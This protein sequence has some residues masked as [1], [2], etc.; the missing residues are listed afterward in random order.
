MSKAQG[1][2]LLKLYELP[3]QYETLDELLTESGGELTPE[4]EDLMCALQ[5][6][7]ETKCERLAAL[8]RR[9]TLQ[10][11][12]AKA[13]ADRLTKLAQSR[14]KKAERWK[15][16]ALYCLQE[17]GRER[18]ETPTFVIRRQNNPA[19]EIEWL[20]QP[21]DIP[22]VF[23]KPPPP[24]PE[25]ELDNRK[26]TALWRYHR[27]VAELAE[28]RRQGDPQGIKKWQ[29]ALEDAWKKLPVDCQ[30]ESDAG[31]LETAPPA[32]PLPEQVSISLKQ[33]LRIA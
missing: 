16:Y 25:P 28:A 27:A 7:L 13:E 21:D 14:Q 31:L 29:A 9:A 32:V 3:E 33:H 22:A 20:G 10:A 5:D 12:L 30:A 26:V 6:N 24:E 19:P 15:A 1:D 17:M 23:R 11:D 18:V 8:I 2:G 4:I